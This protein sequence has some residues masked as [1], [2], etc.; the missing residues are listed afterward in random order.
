MGFFDKLFGRDKAITKEK[1]TAGIVD[2]LMPSFADFG[3]DITKSHIVQEAINSITKHASKLK[4]S[5]YRKDN[6]GNV[7]NGRDTLN[8]I[9]QLQ[10]NKIENGSDFLEKAMYHWLVDNNVF[11]YM[12]FIPSNV[13]VEK[14]VL[15]SMWVIDP[16]ETKVTI[17]DNGDVFLTFWLNNET[18][19]V[20]TSIDNVAVLKR[21][22]GMD[23]FFGRSNNNIKQILSVI[24]TNYQGIENTIKTSAYIRFIVE[25]ATVLN[26]KVKKQKAQE[27]ADDFLNSGTNTGGVIYTDS[28][29]K[30]TQVENKGVYA[31]EKEMQVFYNQVYHYFGTNE[32]I[33]KGDYTDAQWNSFYESTIEVFVNKL[34]IELTKKIFTKNERTRGNRI[35]VEQ[36]KLQQMSIQ[37][38]L[39][40][41]TAT[42]E[43]GLLT[44]NEM[45]ELIYLPPVENGDVRQV[46]LNYVDADKQN[47]YQV[48]EENKV[49]VE[50]EEETVNEDK[51][52][53]DT[54]D[55]E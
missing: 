23:E 14:E 55:V 41:L 34:E 10:P 49:D 6:A 2:Y 4:L 28:A 15:D 22:V 30:I 40:I 20:T 11:I 17:K 16:V 3:D 31:N 26:P 44:L 52:K 29:N 48:G 33:I 19:K 53:G 38:R 35:V 50:V 7:K 8:E 42:K 18:E 9:L 21:N 43:L 1:R 25:S 46:S 12:K 39:N 27:F 24:N 5:H 32:S 13:L 36:S 54:E 45:R 37:S 51:E 47:K